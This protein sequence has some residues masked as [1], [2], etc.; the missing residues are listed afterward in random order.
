MPL[1]RGIAA[2][3]DWKHPLPHLTTALNVREAHRREPTE[4]EP[5]EDDRAKFTSCVPIPARE[6]DGAHCEF[7]HPSGSDERSA[8]GLRCP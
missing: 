2:T 8:R 6:S 1:C 5:G 3:D 7:R 4:V